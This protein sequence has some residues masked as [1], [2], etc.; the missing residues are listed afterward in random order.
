[1]S[2]AMGALG[3]PEVQVGGAGGTSV[4]V[5]AFGNLLKVLSGRVEAE[6]NGGMAKIHSG[7]PEYLQDF[8][9]EAKVDPAVA[10]NRAEVLYELLE[11]TESDASETAEAAEAESESEMEAAE[12]E[13]DA[14]ELLEVYES[15]EA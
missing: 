3:K 11:S 12:A 13:Y 5:S 2:M 6:Y 8:A 7:T 15:E 10:E 1:M 14:M 4:P 9:G